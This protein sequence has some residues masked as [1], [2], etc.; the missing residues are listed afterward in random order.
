MVTLSDAILAINPDAEFEYDKISD[1]LN[2]SGNVKINDT[3]NNYII[4]TEKVTYDKGKE[5]IFT[6]NGSR[7][8]SLENDIEIHEEEKVSNGLEN[9]RQNYM[10][11]HGITWNY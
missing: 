9:G 6:E 4:Y 3:K 1:I 10:V 7:G 8:I 11:T 5:I 2:A